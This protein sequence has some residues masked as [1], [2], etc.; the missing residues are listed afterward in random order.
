MRSEGIWTHM[1]T[2]TGGHL[3]NL[4]FTR[5]LNKPL[6]NN[7]YLFLYG[8]KGSPACLMFF[9]LATRNNRDYKLSHEK[10]NHWSVLLW[11]P[12][13][14]TV[15]LCHSG[16]NFPHAHKKVPTLLQSQNV[17][18]NIFPF[19]VENSGDPFFDFDNA[20]ELTYWECV[21]FML[22]TMSTVGFGDI[23][24][25]T[26]LGRLFMVFFILGALVSSFPFSIISCISTLSFVFFTSGY[27]INDRDL[28][29][30]LLKQQFM[31]YHDFTS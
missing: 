26:V 11:I 30:W 1:D 4:R 14:L 23:Y 9:S 25:K 19:Q 15:V 7:D 3:S 20:Q 6:Q 16:L 21:Y 8:S 22:V 24:C 5:T 31:I 27:I 2:D 28:L 10:K 18:C 29:R 13:Y 12:Y 17:I